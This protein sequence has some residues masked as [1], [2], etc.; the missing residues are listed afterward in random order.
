MLP[1]VGG[2]K[3]LD[4]WWD[5]IKSRQLFSEVTSSEKK[6]VVHATDLTSWLRNREGR[7]REE[8][9]SVNRVRGIES[10]QRLLQ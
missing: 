7:S 5:L 6:Q 8:V 2:K 9:S 4:Y 10:L 1:S 3:I